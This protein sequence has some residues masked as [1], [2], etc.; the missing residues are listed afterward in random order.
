MRC[1]PYRV[2]LVI[3]DTEPESRNKSS[4]VHQNRKSQVGPGVNH[5]ERMHA[6]HLRKDSVLPD[7]IRDGTA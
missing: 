2:D 1:G 7:M 5:S 6:S 3:V 4:R